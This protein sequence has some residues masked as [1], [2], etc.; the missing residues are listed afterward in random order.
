MRGLTLIEAMDSLPISRQLQLPLPM[1]F[2]VD[3]VHKVPGVGAVACGVV[4]YYHVT[5][6]CVVTYGSI[7][8]GEHVAFGPQGTGAILT[9]WSE[10][11]RIGQV[12]VCH[13]LM[14]KL[15]H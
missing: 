10:L 15:R 5:Y 2:M 11:S 9:R 13:R 7:Q 1:R 14:Y 3:A 4:T 12:S 8:V 6:G